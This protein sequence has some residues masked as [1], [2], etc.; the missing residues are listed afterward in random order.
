MLIVWLICAFGLISQSTSIASFNTTQAAITAANTESTAEADLSDTIL[1]LENAE[2]KDSKK[3]EIIKQIRKVNNDGSYTVGYEAVDGTFKIESRDVLGNVKGT[4][5]YVDSNGDIKRVSYTAN[6]TTNGLKSTTAQ[7]IAEEVVHIPRQNRTTYAST[8]TRR[9]ASLAYLMSSTSSPLKANSNVIQAIPK[10]R[11]LLASASNQQAANKNQF[12]ST[13]RKAADFTAASSTQAAQTKQ[14]EPTTTVVYA[15]SIRSTKKPSST[16]RPAIEPHSTKPDKIEISDRFSKV[17]V[18]KDSSTK[19]SIES[20]TEEKDTNKFGNALRRQL[21]EQSEVV[22]SQS[23]DEDS[24][25]LY[26]GVTGTQRPIFTTTSSPRVPALVLAARNRAS[27]LKN[28]ALH[29][30][31]TTQ[32]TTERERERIYSKPPR[33]KLEHRNEDDDQPTTQPSS[34][35]AYL[36]QSPVP[37]VQIPA[38]RDNSNDA[39]EQ[40]TYRHPNT[41]LPRSR[42]YLR[43]SQSTNPID[44]GPRRII[45]PVQVQETYTQ[46]DLENEQYLRETT[47]ANSIKSS[48]TTS[49]PEQYTTNEQQILDSY[50]PARVQRLQ[51]QQQPIR[52]D[53]EQ[54]R[55]Q[56]IPLPVQ[57]PYGGTPNP[58]YDRPLTARD[59]EKLLNL[60]QYRHL[61]YQQRSNYL[62]G[63]FNSFGNQYGGYNGYGNGYG[64]GFGNGYY[65]NPYQN[66]FGY[67]QQIPR[68]PPLYNMFDPRYRSSHLPPVPPPPR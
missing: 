36:T 7:S 34:E 29:S 3:L 18:N 22:Y 5:G 55:Q 35:N 12:T 46:N 8:T 41:Y 61:Q 54:Q 57:P 32:Q 23:S 10:R 20:N 13:T 27:L 56:S 16:P 50:H 25:H 58:Y 37:V 60:L 53:Y 40:R 9:P 67:P 26:S 38:N 24:A 68:P 51:G 33:R 4:Y 11:I 28:A 47:D 17:T 14:S 43:Q 49:L 44:N 65:N 1:D 15:T 2:S 21:P 63:L 30:S 31:T 42:E 59:F 64:G 39:V 62:P 52:G 66:P 6:N 19:P 45:L 48:S